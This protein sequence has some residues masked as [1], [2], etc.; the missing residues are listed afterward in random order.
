M[1]DVCLLLL[2]QFLWGW[3][4]WNGFWNDFFVLRCYLSLG[5]EFKFKPDIEWRGLARL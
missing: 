3:R 4:K 5:L 2:E 1:F